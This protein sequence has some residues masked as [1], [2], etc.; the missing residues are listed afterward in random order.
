MSKAGFILERFRVA[1][2]NRLKRSVVGENVEAEGQWSTKRPR[3]GTDDKV[4]LPEAHNT[5]QTQAEKKA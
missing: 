5:G 3:K 2:K 4:Q 1:S